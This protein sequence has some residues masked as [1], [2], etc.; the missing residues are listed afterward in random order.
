MVLFLYSFKSFQGSHVDITDD[1]DVRRTRLFFPIMQT[2]FHETWIIS[3]YNI[4]AS[5]SNMGWMDGRT[6][7]YIQLANK[8]LRKEPHV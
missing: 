3:T 1:R 7:R 8:V 6:E 5:L 2:E 4:D